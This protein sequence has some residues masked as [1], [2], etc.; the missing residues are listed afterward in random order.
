MRRSVGD[1]IRNLREEQELKQC[2]LA[3]GLGLAK[4][5]LSQYENGKRTPDLETA[6]RI[7]SKFKVSLDYLCGIHDEKYNPKDDCFLS[8]IKVFN[9]CSD[10]KKAKIIKIAKQIQREGN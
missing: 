9:T 3:H 1:T 7:A 5:T 8:L 4:S 2:A 10:D 6:D